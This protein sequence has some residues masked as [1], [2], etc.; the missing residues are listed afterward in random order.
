MQIDT[1]F[2]ISQEVLT[3][4]QDPLFW[5]NVDCAVSTGSAPSLVY[6]KVT[7]VRSQKLMP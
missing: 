3:I 1:N 5:G 7:Q 4:L 6:S 2:K